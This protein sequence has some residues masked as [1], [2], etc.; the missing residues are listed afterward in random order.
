MPFKSKLAQR[1]AFWMAGTASLIFAAGIISDY[2]LSREHIIRNSELEARQVVVAAVSDLEA[3]F[4]GVQRSTDLFARVLGDRHLPASEMENLL[5]RTVVERDDLYGSAIALDP[6]ASGFARGYSPY[7]Y[8]D[9]RA[10]TAGNGDLLKYANLA[11]TYPRGYVQE[12]WFRQAQLSGKAIWTEPYFDADGGKAL[13][14]TYSSPIYRKQNG[15]PAFFGV[16]TA[17]ITLKSIQSCLNRIHLG[18]S[19]FAFM[20]SREG[21]L[22]SYPD[23]HYLLQPFPS[24]FPAIAGSQEWQGALFRAQEGRSSIERLACPAHDGQ[25]LLAYSPFGST[26]W[27]LMVLYPEAEMLSELNEHLW[28]VV[29]IGLACLLALLLS[30]I[31]ISRSIT[32]PLTALTMAA[33]RLGEGDLDTQLPEAEGDD[34]VAHLVTAFRH[35]KQRLREFIARVEQDAAS[36][37]RLQGELNAAQ[38]IQMEMLPQAGNARVNAATHEIHARLIP[39]KTVGGDLYSWFRPDEDQLFLI[40]GDVSDKGVPAALFMAR[41]ITLLQQHLVADE[42]PEQVLSLLNQQLV[43]RNDACMFA[44]LSCIRLNLRTGDMLWA[45]AGHSA[46]LLRRH[47]QVTAL[48]QENG[49]A[50]GLMPVAEFPVN[51]ISLQPLDLL[52]LCT[53]GIDEAFNTAREQ[54]G[55]ERLASVLQAAG[56][57]GVHE[58]GE[59]VLAAVVE[60]AGVEPQ[61]DD[62]TLLVFAWKGERRLLIER[63]WRNQVSQEFPARLKTF[64][65]M[66]AWMQAWAR[67]NDISAEVLHDLRLVAEEVF[68]N[69]VHYGGLPAGSNI[70]VLIARDADALALEFIDAGRPWNPLQQAPE[71][72]LGLPSEDTGIGGLGVH[73]V[74]ELTQEQRYVRQLSENRFCVLKQLR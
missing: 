58:V 1:L 22:V 37:N 21:S 54:F 32:R 56:E 53:D 19:G 57:G 68:V 27:A 15:V 23:D 51:H 42:S 49:P 18:K 26:G 13:M 40:I 4:L 8:H 3:V 52:L 48:A 65:A 43:E 33:D 10:G 24:V 14:T 41:V 62:I 73:L 64:D 50:L 66:L 72:E 70:T 7:Y 34:E 29:G 71:P 6:Q 35:M 59:S 69:I 12:P 28:K 38:Q 17:D 45:S 25:C 16:V 67:S 55:T 46:P 11:E 5:R 47:G 36:R 2:R 60:H 44:T 61:S 74:C 20:V 9:G 39:A 31:L 63:D 30:I